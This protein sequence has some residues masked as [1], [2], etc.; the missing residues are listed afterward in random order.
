MPVSPL[1]G[2]AAAGEKR[3]G[4]T[5]FLQHDV[6]AD[7]AYSWNN[8]GCCRDHNDMMTPQVISETSVPQISM[9]RVEADGVSVFYRAAG[10]VGAPVVLLLHGQPTWSYLYHTVIPVL[11][12]AGLRAVAPDLIGYGRSDKPTDPTDYTFAR[13]V[14]W[15]QSLVT[16]LDLRDITLVAQD[17]G[18]PIGFSVLAGTAHPGAGTMIGGTLLTGLLATLV[19]ILVAYYVA[20][21]TV[22]FGFDPDNTGVPLITSSMDLAGVI[23]FLLVLSFLGVGVQEPASSWGNMLNQAR[24]IRAL[25]SFPWLL[26]VPGLAI[27]LTVMAFNFLG[28]GLRDA[29]DPRRVTGSKS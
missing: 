28:D 4:K 14:G 24:S 9:H 10:P 13:H 21:L 5:P 6:E 18:G 19:A 26:Y 7:T 25:T 22:R 16:G 8:A 12:D 29:L 1:W 17:W 11:I 2:E 20:I 23:S 15:V 27:F 3:Y